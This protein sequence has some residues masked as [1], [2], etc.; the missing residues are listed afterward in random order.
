MISNL[1]R[2]GTTVLALFAMLTLAPANPAYAQALY[3]SI[4]GTVT[5]ASGAAIPGATVKVTHTET[6]QSRD[7]RTNEAG[8][9]SITTLPTGAYDVTVSHDGFQTYASRGLTVG[10]SGVVRVNAALEVGAITE[11]VRVNAQAV[12]L[13]TDSAEVRS[14]IQTKSLEELP[15]PGNRNYQ[16]LL[17]MVPGFSPPANQHS[18]SASPSRALTFSANGT[19]RNSNNIRIEGATATN[20]WLPHVSAYVP[21]LEA[22]REVS[23]VTGSLDAEQGLT[24][25]AAVNV[26]MKSGTNGLHGSLFE[27]HTDNA[28]KAKPFFLPSNHRNPK[29]IDNQLGGTIGGPIRKDKLFYFLSYDGQFIRQSAAI[30][31]TVPTAAIKAGDMSASPNPIYDPLTGAPD[32]TGRT[33]FASKL[34]PQTRM[35]Q[36]ALRFL[37]LI[38]GANIN[39]DLTNNYYANGAYSVS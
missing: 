5:D 11:S 38:P 19:S 15:V 8:G 2:W 33:P 13:Q 30:I 4:V 21:G 16:N 12:T 29:T 22:I 27:Y 37:P 35:D 36:A 20:V 26:Q 7:A 28:M 24:G 9:F 10:V 18:V 25:G 32:G 6:N 31:N 1:N 3:G 23:V 34:V 17:I 14:Q 39:S